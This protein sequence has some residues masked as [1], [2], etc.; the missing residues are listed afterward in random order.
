MACVTPNAEMRTASTASGFYN[1]IR[2]PPFD[3]RC[4]TLT[5]QC[6]YSCDAAAVPPV[7][8]TCVNGSVPLEKLLSPKTLGID[9]SIKDRKR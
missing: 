4:I 1:P 9:E 6:D 5:S 3:D 8:N 2:G 7:S